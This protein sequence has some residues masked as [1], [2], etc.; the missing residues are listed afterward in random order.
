[1]LDTEGGR[2]K[3]ASRIVNPVCVFWNFNLSTEEY[4]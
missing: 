2:R 1:M 4:V 3:H